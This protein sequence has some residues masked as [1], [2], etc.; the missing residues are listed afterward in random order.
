MLNEKFN[1]KVIDYLPNKDKQS[2]AYS[3]GIYNCPSVVL[4]NF[5]DNY[6]SV[7]TLAHEIGHA[8]HTELSNRTQPIE[9]ADYVI[10][11]AEVGS[12]VNEILLNLLVRKTANKEERIALIFRLLNDVRTTIYRQTMFSEFEQFSHSTLEKGQPLTYE[13]FNNKYYEL[14]KKYFGD[15]LILPDELKYEWARIPHFYND[16]YVYEY[17]TGYISAL[18]IV[19]KL[20]EDE[21][22]YKQYINFL[23]GGCT[24]SPVELLKDVGV[25]LTTNQPYE[26]A[27]EFINSQIK[28]L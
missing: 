3:S 11:V 18:C 15:T 1:Q 4:M 5:V 9:L 8:M 19:Q 27:F 23:K 10:F 25:D 28:E 13:D 20:L 26:K 22:Y 14:N 21:N 12:T 7:S 24:K 17:S 2:G 16:F 6:E